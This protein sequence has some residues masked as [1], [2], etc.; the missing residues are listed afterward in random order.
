MMG[1]SLGAAGA[2]EAI[3][4]LLALQH[5]FLPPNINFRAPDEDFDLDIVAN[6]SRPAEVRTVLSNSFGFGGTNA[7]ILM[8][9][10]ARMS[11]RICGMGWVTPLGSGVD[12]VWERLLHGDEGQP[13]QIKDQFSER[14]YCVFR[15]PT[16][17]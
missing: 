14:S 15:V 5:Q 2:I 8:Q 3:V 7:S 16:P 1:H 17:L 4:C 10:F 11:L 6:Q 9:R 13:E 12:P